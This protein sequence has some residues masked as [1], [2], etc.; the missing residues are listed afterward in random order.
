MLWRYAGSP[1]VSGRMTG[2]VDADQIGGYA[3][4]AMLWAT[5]A[6]IIGGKGNGQL[7]PK[8]YATR[9]EVAAMLMRY[10]NTLFTK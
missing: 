5:K 6:G 8:G 1:S 9:A 3:E 10:C 4:D 7:D 2:F